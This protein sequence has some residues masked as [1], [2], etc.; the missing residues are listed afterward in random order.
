MEL[1]YRSYKCKID[2]RV[3]TSNIDKLYDKREDEILST[4]LS[5]KDIC[6]NPAKFFYETPECIKHLILWSKNDMTREKIII[7]VDK[8]L[9]ENYPLVK[10]WQYDYNIG[11]KTYN[12]FHIH[13]FIEI[14]P[15]KFVVEEGRIRYSLDFFEILGIFIKYFFTF[16]KTN[17]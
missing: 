6:I 14:D 12:I 17:Q 3:H 5:D 13:L 11:D 1:W 8:W 7:Y 10:R 15:Y 16:K 2:K 9:F 4:I